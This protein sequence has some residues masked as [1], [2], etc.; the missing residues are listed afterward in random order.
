MMTNVWRSP[1]SLALIVTL[2]TAFWAFWTT[3][4]DVVERWISDPQYSHGFLVPIFAGYLLWKR[5]QHLVMTDLHP[6]WWG[7]GIVLLAAVM[8]MLGHYLY[9][10]WLDNGSLLI[11]LAGISVA[12]GGTRA[13]VWAWPSILFLVFM[14]PLPYRVQTMLGGTLQSIAT[15]VSVYVIQTLGIPALAEGNVILLTDT[16]VG[17]VEA[18]NGLSM[19]ITFFAISTAVAILARRTLI[20]RI[21]I[22]LSAV[23]IA[24]MANVARITMTSILFESSKGDWGR[25][26][27]H[28][29]AGWMMMPLAVGLLLL[30]LFILGHSIVTIEKARH[31]HTETTVSPVR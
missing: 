13:L 30:E 21:L 11:C 24:V 4:T 20:E 1:A 23:P 27:F 10:P 3:L 29:L 2:L 8:R 31:S 25:V 28:D 12:A 19:L 5:R 7:T 17:V 16:K 15:E 22:V 9:Q 14:L 6:R 26:V 18:C